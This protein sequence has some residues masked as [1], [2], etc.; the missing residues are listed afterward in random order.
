[1]QMKVTLFRDMV[2]EG[3]RSMDRYA[4]CLKSELGKNNELEINEFRVEP[5]LPSSKVKMLWRSRVYPFFSKFSQGSVN[6]VL[7]HSYAHL[8]NYLD[9]KKTVVT[10][11]DLIPLEY[12]EDGKVLERFKKTVDNLSKAQVIIADSQSTKR[13]L[14]S[15]LSI[16]EDKIRVIYLGLDRAL[17]NSN[18]ATKWEI[19]KE[20]GLPEGK[21]ILNH[22]NNLVYKNVSGVL[23]AFKNILSND[24]NTYLVRTHS[25]SIVQKKIAED[26]GVLSHYI[27]ILHPDDDT[28]CNLYIASDVLLSPSLKEGFGLTVLEAMSLGLPVVV[29]QGTSLQEI[30]GEVGVLVDPKNIDEVAS[31]TLAVLKGDIVLNSATLLERATLFSWEKTAEQTTSVYQEI[32][33][34]I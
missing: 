33:T 22:G 26:L 13:D 25:L 24:P 31:K 9:S 3:W 21:I 2:A 19:R 17:K 16:K 32:A 29:S 6:H 15:K 34:R 4:D 23:K 8:L 10:C 27:E 18:Q 11:H 30:A 20:L 1:M 5:P 14:M 28:L 12:E 7:D